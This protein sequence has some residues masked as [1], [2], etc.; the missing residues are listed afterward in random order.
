MPTYL[1]TGGAGFIGSHLCDEL[2]K[3]AK[4]YVLDDLSTGSEKNLTKEVTLIKGDISDYDLV[5][6][7]ISRVDGCFHLA[8]VVSVPLCN[9]DF[10]KAHQVNLTATANLFATAVKLST[11]TKTIPVVFASSCA[12]YGNPSSFPITEK[13]NADPISIYAA[14]KLAAEYYG[15]FMS[16]LHGWPFTALRLFNVYGPRQQL[17]NPYSGVISIFL[18]ALL[19]GNPCNFYGSGNQSRDFVSVY[20]VIQFFIK[21]MNS[22]TCPG[23]IYNVCTGKST[24]IKTIAELLSEDLQK[25]LTVVHTPPLIGDIEYSLGSPVFT[26]EELGVRAKVAIESGL[27]D[28]VKKVLEEEP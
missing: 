15:R 28:L 19:K 22:S 4:V 17:D 13:T 11:P 10:L 21:A 12:V 1:V 5:R 25:K 7:L 2:V 8:A 16:E 18:N 24:K 14:T 20:D 3:T 27:K 23:Q 26:Q 6:D 9:D